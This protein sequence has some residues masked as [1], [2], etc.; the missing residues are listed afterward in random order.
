MLL[1]STRCLLITARMWLAYWPYD[2]RYSAFNKSLILHEETGSSHT[3]NGTKRQLPYPASQH[4]DKLAPCPNFRSV[5]KWT[6]AGYWLAIW[7][8]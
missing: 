1:N 8:F 5:E 6:N 3:F 4:S 7:A 2:I